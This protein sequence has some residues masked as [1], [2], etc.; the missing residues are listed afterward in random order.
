[1][2]AGGLWAL[3][4]CAQAPYG[5]GVAS[6]T[7][8][9]WLSVGAALATIVL[10]TVAYLLTGSVGLLSDAIESSVNLVAA[11][12][13]VFALQLAARP[14]DETHTWGH[15]KAEYFS[16][17]AEGVMIFIAAAAVIY[18]AI[19]RLIHPRA[20]EQVGIGLAVSAVAAV[21]NFFVARVLLRAGKAYRSITLTADSKHLMTDVWT[22]AGVI[23]GVALVALLHWP[24]LDPIVAI[25]VG[26][27]ILVAGGKLIRNS[28]AGLM[29]AALPAEDLAQVEAALAPH[30]RDGLVDFHAVRTRAAGQQRF[31]SM[32]LLVPGQWSVHD[33]HE[34]AERVEADVRAALPGA[35]VMVHIE[36]VED[37]ASYADIS[38]VRGTGA[39]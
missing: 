23:V 13:A 20:L 26:V 15:G 5:S 22:S 9:A 17:G 7:R 1:M 8:Y 30:R 31:V 32:H 19:D 35:H 4:R 27:N 34:L 37:E 36:P 6:L 38:L 10:K 12:I 2:A 28:S 14:A 3:F 33:G 24:P 21:L 11:V 18:T 16:A 39:G 25:L 29:D